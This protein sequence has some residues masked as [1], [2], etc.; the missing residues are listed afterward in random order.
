M[1]PYHLTE[2]TRI[3]LMAVS[4]DYR[5]RLQ[6]RREQRAADE[7]RNLLAREAGKQLDRRFI[8]ALPSLFG[9]LVR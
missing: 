5:Q 7:A 9:E 3:E 6:A 4:A 1:N 2:Q 8:G